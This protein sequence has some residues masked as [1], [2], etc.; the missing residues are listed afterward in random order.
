[1]KEIWSHDCREGLARADLADLAITML[2]G[3]P[4]SAAARGRRSQP[5]DPRG[6]HRYGLSLSAVG[7]ATAAEG[8]EEKW[9][10]VR[11]SPQQVIELGRAHGTLNAA[12]GA[13]RSDTFSLGLVLLDRYMS[14]GDFQDS[15]LTLEEMRQNIQES[16]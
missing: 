8:R 7:S 16:L 2:N 4:G 1:M 11:V 15:D 5:R 6:G 14:A 10:S 12:F 9:T 13:S 3:A